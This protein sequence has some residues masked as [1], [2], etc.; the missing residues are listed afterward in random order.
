MRVERFLLS[1]V[2]D[3]L[4]S[5]AEELDELGGEI[6]TRG[7]LALTRGAVQSARRRRGDQAGK[8]ETGSENCR[9]GG[10]DGG[11]DSDARRRDCERNERGHEPSQVQT[12]Q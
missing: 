4:R 11:H 1:P 9:G 3:E 2:D 6:C 5:A 10:Q 12:L 8:D 7:C